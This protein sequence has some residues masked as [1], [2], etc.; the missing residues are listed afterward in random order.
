MLA[1]YCLLPSQS[2]VIL[3]YC[4]R[5]EVREELGMWIT[6]K[7]SFSIDSKNSELEKERKMKTVIKDAEYANVQYIKKDYP[8]GFGRW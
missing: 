5:D 6:Q 3:S 4:W 7:Q 2:I 1:S 8:S